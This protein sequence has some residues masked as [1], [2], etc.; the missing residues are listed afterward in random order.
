MVR[1]AAKNHP[2]LPSSRRPTSTALARCARGRRLHAVRAAVARRRGVPHT[3]AYDVRWPVVCP[4]GHNDPDVWWP[5][6]AGQRS[7]AGAA[8]LWRELA[9]GRGRPY[10]DLRQGRDLAQAEQLGGKEMSTTTTSTR[11]RPTDGVRLRGADVA[12]IKHTNPCGIAVGDDIADA[13]A[14]AHAC[15]P[16][17][18]Y[19][20]VIAANRP[21]SEAM[22]RQMAEMFTEVVVARLRD[23]RRCVLARRRTF[24]CSQRATAGKRRRV[25]ARSAAGYSCRRPI[26]S[27]L[28]AT[29]RRAGRWWRAPHCPPPTSSSSVRMAGMPCRQ[30]ECDRPRRGGA[31]VG[32]GMGQ[33]NRVDS[34]RLAVARAADRARG[35]SRRRTHSFRL[36]TAFR[37]CIDAGVRA[38]VQP[39]GSVRDEEVVAAAGP[40]ASRCT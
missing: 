15:D 1:A 13:H 40:P 30:V 37:C 23:G 7:S 34:A 21:V 11:S 36:R 5:Q 28:T 16:V 24:G 14:K 26:G 39:G 8:A 10:V 33:V 3:A 25:A 19:G 4:R 20:G 32:V 17:S 18:A 35:R 27:R 29:T 12:I 38:V 6:F 22:A 2:A 9:P 31:T